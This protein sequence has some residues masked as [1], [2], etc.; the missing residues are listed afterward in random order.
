MLMGDILH[1]PHHASHQPAI[2]FRGA[3]TLLFPI[4]AFVYLCFPYYNR[5]FQIC[6]DVFLKKANEDSSI[7]CFDDFILRIKQFRTLFVFVLKIFSLKRIYPQLSL[8]FRMAG[9]FFVV[10]MSN[11]SILIMLNHNEFSTKRSIL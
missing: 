7:S 2:L 10:N 11:D 8:F 9:R 4:I 1:E 6:Q 5:P 3:N